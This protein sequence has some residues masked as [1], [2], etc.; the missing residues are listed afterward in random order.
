[1]HEKFIILNY[2]TEIFP[3]KEILEKNVF[4]IPK[5][6]EL[7]HVWRKQTGNNELTYN[8]NLILRK[9]MQRLPDEALFYKVY[10]RWIARVIAIHYANKISYSAHP[11]MRVHLAGTGSVSD[12]HRDAKVTDRLDQINCYLPFT[13]V[14]EGST[15]W[16]ET[17]YGS[18]KYTPINL[19]YGQAL[20]WDGGMLKHG[21]Y[22]NDTSNARVSCDLR[23]HPKKPDKVNKP[24]DSILLGRKTQSITPNKR[25]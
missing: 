25:H 9:L 13:D 17:D 8:D 2:N 21:T 14:F 7:H 16:C 10:H 19:K 5:L 12:F 15:L 3:F 23:F 6:N 11:K 20:L 24:W 22:K 18:E 4:K 1:M